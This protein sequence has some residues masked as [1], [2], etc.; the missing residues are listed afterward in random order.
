VSADEPGDHGTDT[1]GAAGRPHAPRGGAIGAET[2]GCDVRVALYDVDSKI[3]NLALMKLSRFHK[4][5]GDEVVRYAPLWREDYGKVYASKIFLF[6]DGSLLDP[7]QMTIGGT[8]WDIATRLP[9]SIESLQP[10]YTFYNYPHSIGFTMRGCRFNCKFCVVPEKEGRPSTEN[11]IKDIWQQR[12]SDFIVLLDNDFFGNPEWFKRIVEIRKHDLRV[13]FSQG[14]NIRIIT[15]EQAAALASVRFSNLHATS[16]QV[17]FAWDR[18]NDE[19]LID[20]GFDRCVRAGLKPAQMA[21]FVLIGFD[22]TPEQDL[23]R[24]MKLRGKGADP[25]VMP[26]RKADPYQQA[27]AR[28][29]NHKAVFKSVSWEEYR[30]GVKNSARARQ[31]SLLIGDTA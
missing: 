10:D 25:Y 12:D 22:T 30:G 5:R 4:E 20:A 31:P 11:T 28:W 3:P 2:G 6:S 14:L 18:W 21:F 26:F 27:F 13:C 9:D 16:R 23:Y 1:E 29:V 7:E 8:G 24:V 17:Y 19:K 15:D